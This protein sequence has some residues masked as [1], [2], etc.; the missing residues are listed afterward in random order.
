MNRLLKKVKNPLAGVTAA[1]ASE[2]PLMGMA[3]PRV[4][5]KQQH[6]K[7]HPCAEP[8]TSP[9]TGPWTTVICGFERAQ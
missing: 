5:W 6:L 9:L 4:G 3:A 8:W 7:W 1:G 2:A